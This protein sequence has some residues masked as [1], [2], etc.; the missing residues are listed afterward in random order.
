MEI[1]QI[2]LLIAA[3]SILNI[4]CFFIGAKVGQKVIK[5]EEIKAPNLNP[6]KVIEE[7]KESKE[8]REEQ[9][10]FNTMMDNINNYDGTGLGQKDIN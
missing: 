8:Y 1:L 10:R 2:T 6:V 7:Y 4:V 3:I 5:G 9:D